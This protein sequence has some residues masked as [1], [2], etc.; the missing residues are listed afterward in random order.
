MNSP[1]ASGAGKNVL[2]GRGRLQ[3]W[4]RRCRPGEAKAQDGPAMTRA[5]AERLAEISD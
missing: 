4:I 1:A 2:F 3:R 5:S